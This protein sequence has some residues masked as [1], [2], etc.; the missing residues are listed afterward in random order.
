[1]ERSKN[2]SFSQPGG[3]LRAARGVSPGRSWLAVLAL[4]LLLPQAAGARSLHW[5]ALEV[6]ARLDADGRLHVVERQTMVFDGDWNGGERSFELGV[7][8]RIDFE[9]IARIDPATG[10][11]V[12]LVE[13][14]L[15]RVDH[16]AWVDG[17]T[18]RWRSRL[19][20]DPPFAMQS[21]VYLLEYSLSRVLIERRGVYHLDHDFAFPDRH[22]DIE[23]FALDLELHDVW[24]P[25]TPLATHYELGRIPPGESFIVTTELAYTGDG[26]PAAA[27]NNVPA[28]SRFAIALAASLAIV[29]LFW[30][31]YRHE[32]RR[33]RFAAP[34]VPRRIDRAWLEGH[35]FDLRPEEVGALWDRTVGPPEV[36]ATLARLVAEEKLRSSVRDGGG[37]WRR[38][39][40][41]E[42]EMLVDRGDL[43]SGDRGLIDKLFFD[44]RTVTDTEA[45]R[46][47]Y[48]STGFD[49]SATIRPQIEARLEG[50]PAYGSAPPGPSHRPFWLASAGVAS[51]MALEGLTRGEGALVVGA[52][53]MIVSVPLAA[54]IPLAIGYSHWNRRLGLACF[55]FMR[56][57]KDDFGSTAARTACSMLRCGVRSMST[58]RT[59]GR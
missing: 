56:T 45:V 35:L 40:V 42:L 27:L 18:L 58:L 22:G 50:H 7:G 29:L 14:D 10:E 51:A 55:A 32:A 39:R 19:P 4:S 13:G 20:T 25:A 21:M 15:D 23:R 16:F 53:L 24:Q 2:A 38:Q 43:G 6:E 9:G 36:A 28:A 30:R 44:G 26:H 47:H 57:P 59:R 37:F 12:E 31:F 34:E 49:P 41:L 5:S 48:K 8:S 54:A 11:R 46:E 52:L 33:G 3:R 17:K 1:M